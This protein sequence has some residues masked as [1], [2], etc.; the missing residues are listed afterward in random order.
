MKGL[1]ARDC[2]DLL[3][4][5]FHVHMRFGLPTHTHIHFIWHVLWCMTHYCV[6][7]EIM[8]VMALGVCAFTTPSRH[9]QSGHYLCL[10]QRE[11]VCDYKG[12]T[13]QNMIGRCLQFM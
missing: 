7:T 4:D 11:S 3:F 8:G 5:S 2:G 10:C 9:G 1:A 6:M 12:I 13:R